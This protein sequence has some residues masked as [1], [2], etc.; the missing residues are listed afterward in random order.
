MQH[1]WVLNVIISSIVKK[2]QH[3]EMNMELWNRKRT[4]QSKFVFHNPR[5]NISS[6][7][8]LHKECKFM[9]AE[10]ER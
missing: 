1:F 7:V 6:T 9:A 4:F 3:A 10:F 5:K 2:N 8:V